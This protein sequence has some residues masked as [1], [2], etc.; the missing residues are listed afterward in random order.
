MSK[1]VG[2]VHVLLCI[3]TERQK[4]EIPI[5]S[6]PNQMIW[7]RP[8]I[9][10]NPSQV[11]EPRQAG[12][13]LSLCSSSVFVWTSLRGAG[14]RL[15]LLQL[16][17]AAPD[18]RATLGAGTQGPPMTRFN[19]PTCTTSS[20]AGRHLRRRSMKPSRIGPGGPARNFPD[21]VAAPLCLSSSRAGSGPS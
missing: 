20:P 2:H 6:A 12:C 9:V 16:M 7:F 10:L 21:S 14:A 11:H 13:L 18:Q 19:R 3:L 15:W 17:Q 8:R 1:I 5:A 4:T